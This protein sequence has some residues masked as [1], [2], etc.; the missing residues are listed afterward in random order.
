MREAWVLNSFIPLNV[1]EEQILKQI[2]TKL[3]FDPCDE[4]HRLRS[5][6]W[7]EPDRVR[8]P[9]VVV[10]QLTGGD[11][12]REQQCW[13]E[14]DL[15]I[16]RSRGANTGLREYLSEIEKRLTSILDRADL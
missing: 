7:D 6:S 2:K 8:N 15:E 11:I 5:N 4:A 16:M 13:E 14:T 12:I 1:E 3:S 9:K 10:E